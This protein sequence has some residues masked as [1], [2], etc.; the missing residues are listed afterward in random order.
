VSARIAVLTLFSAAVLGCGKTPQAANRDKS[1]SASAGAPASAAESETRC[2]ELV[3]ENAPAQASARV[4]VELDTFYAPP[5]DAKAFHSLTLR[6]GQLALHG[7]AARG[8]LSAL[9][10]YAVEH[11][12]VTVEATLAAPAAVERDARLVRVLG[13]RSL[14]SL[15]GE[16]P[17]KADARAALCRRLAADGAQLTGEQPLTAA[18][19]LSDYY[20]AAHADRRDADYAFSL[21]CGGESIVAYGERARLGELFALV[22][23]GRAPPIE[24]T[25][26]ADESGSLAIRAWKKPAGP[27]RDEL[28]ASLRAD[29]LRDEKRH[30]RQRGL[31]EPPPASPRELAAALALALDRLHGDAFEGRVTQLMRRATPH[32]EPALELLDD[33]D[34]LGPVI[35]AS[36]ARHR[37]LGDLLHTLADSRVVLRRCT[38]ALL[39]VG[40]R[41]A[42]A[43]WIVAISDAG[44]L[45]GVFAQV[46]EA[47]QYEAVAGLLARG[48]PEASG[49]LEALAKARPSYSGEAVNAATLESIAARGDW[50]RYEY[51]FLIVPGFTPVHARGQLSI[52]ELPPAQQRLDLAVADFE[53]RRA[54]YILVSGG[55]VHPSGTPYN[56]ALMMRDYLMSRGVPLDRI[57]VD[58]FARHSTT[59]LR[60]AGR[61][62]LAARRTRAL[63]VTGFDGGH[64]DQA[65][66]FSHPVLSTF[67]SRCKSELGYEVGALTGVDDHHIAFRPAP[68]VVRLNYRDPL[69]V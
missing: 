39:R 41:A 48:G 38:Q 7:F 25:V 26:A 62:M 14:E 3:A 63:I 49:A 16:L 24:L 30:A 5:Y 59:N 66:Y 46:I 2:R 67:R 56:E 51:D 22:A 52:A 4:V 1:A 12:H 17:P 31:E 50:D 53:K 32:L 33:A 55:S 18:V 20:D 13:W 57:L 69:D 21:D 45:P 11:P 29:G 8:A 47:G 34:A 58:P 54:P 36:T 40:D 15:G 43:H 60:N 37:L 64:F 28:L 68:E 42:M 9:F 44:A 27:A 19:S 35:A 61:M 65:F 6:C 23:A 10:D